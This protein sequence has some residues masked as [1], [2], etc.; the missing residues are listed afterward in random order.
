MN[1]N[2][3]PRGILIEGPKWGRG[4]ADSEHYAYL[5]QFNNLMRC[6]DAHGF[7]I[8]HYLIDNE[9]TLGKYEGEFT[10]ILLGK[11]YSFFQKRY[12]LSLPQG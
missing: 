4:F 3:V 12:A 8:P 9:A 7:P 11:G 6:T 1:T 5:W 2:L 10:N